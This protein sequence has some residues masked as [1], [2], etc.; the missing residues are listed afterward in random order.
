MASG[1]DAVSALSSQASAIRSH[2]QTFALK[3]QSRSGSGGPWKVVLP[4]RGSLSVALTP[5]SNSWRAH[6]RFAAD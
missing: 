5:R 6:R 4:E 2:A 1:I 3:A